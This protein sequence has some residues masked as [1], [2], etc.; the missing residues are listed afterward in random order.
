MG[1]VGIGPVLMCRRWTLLFFSFGASHLCILFPFLF[2]FH[3]LFATLSCLFF[4]CLFTDGKFTAVPRL[5]FC[6]SLH[7]KSSISSFRFTLTCHV[8][9]L[10]RFVCISILHF[11]PFLFHS[12]PLCISTSALS[13]LFLSLFSPPFSISYLTCLPLPVCGLSHFA[14]PPLLTPLLSALISPSLLFSLFPLLALFSLPLLSSPH[15]PTPF[16]E[17]STTILSHCLFCFL[18][19]SA[20][21]VYEISPISLQIFCLCFWGRERNYFHFQLDIHIYCVSYFRILQSPG[22]HTSRQTYVT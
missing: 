11:P 4:V 15:F 14:L 19:S 10:L 13:S 7:F 16:T 2:W 21:L 5:Y 8:I 12:L 1:R 3:F 20:S 9:F 22:S 6:F 17:A 18:S